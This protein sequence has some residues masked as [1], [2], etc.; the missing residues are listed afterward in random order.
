MATNNEIVQ[1]FIT[2]RHGTYTERNAHSQQIREKE[3]HSILEGYG[4]ALYGLKFGGTVVIFNSWYG[5]SSTTSSHLNRLKGKA[6]SDEHLNVI[7]TDQFDQP[8]SRN[9]SKILEDLKC[10]YCQNT[11]TTKQNR[12]NGLRVC[13]KNRCNQRM[14]KGENPKATNP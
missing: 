8:K 11:L 9:S 1:N 12:Q 13:D 7:V 4:H 3:N 6:K 10:D 5:Y 14:A 2:G